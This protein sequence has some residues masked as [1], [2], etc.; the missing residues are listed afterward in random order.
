[1]LKNWCPISLLSVVYK[2]LSSVIASRI[3]S[4]LNQLIS[5]AQTGFLPGRFIGENTRLIH[6]LL[7]FTQNENIPGMLVLIDFQ[8]AFDSVAW[9]F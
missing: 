2:M 1:M 3:T 9:H 5:S 8:K 6:D 7:H 4:V